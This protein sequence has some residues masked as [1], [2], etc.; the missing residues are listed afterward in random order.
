MQIIYIFIPVSIFRSKILINHFTRQFIVQWQISSIGIVIEKYTIIF[1]IGNL[2][3]KKNVNIQKKLTKNYSTK[4]LPWSLSR[5]IV[6]LGNNIG[7]TLE[8]EMCS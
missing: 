4:K 6:D 1:R 3:K 2:K 5:L 7:C 8:F